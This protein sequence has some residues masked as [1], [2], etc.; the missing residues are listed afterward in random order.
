MLSKTKI[1]AKLAFYTLSVASSVFMILIFYQFGENQFY[2]IVWG[3]VG[4]GLDLSK[5]FF[6]TQVTNAMGMRQ[7]VKK[8]LVAI[9]LLIAFAC[10]ACGIIFGISSIQKI[11]KINASENASMAETAIRID[12]AEQKIKSISE[13]DKTETARANI[14]RQIDALARQSDI[15]SNVEQSIFISREVQNLENQKKNLGRESL[16][17]KKDETLKT[18]TQ[19]KKEYSSQVLAEQNVKGAFQVVAEVTH[20]PHKAVMVIFLFFVIIT[21][22]ILIAYTSASALLP[23]KKPTPKVKK[24][25]A[26]KKEAYQLAL[27]AL[28]D[29]VANVKEKT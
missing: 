4:I 18:L 5:I 3:A 22:E 16:D 12:D 14:Q 6:R 15:V 23:S 19:L 1:I 29:S 2:K 25:D 21:M 27:T 20:I 17:A 28:K 8:E 11:D 13:S 9:Y 26:G 7:K 24:K 10:V